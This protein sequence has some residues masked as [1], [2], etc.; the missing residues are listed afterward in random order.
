MK[1]QTNL[2]ALLLAFGAIP[3]VSAAEL[4]KSG[5][6]S[7]HLGWV[8]KGE[9]QALGAN[10]TVTSATIDGVV[11]NDAG[12]GFLNRARADCSGLLDI[13]QGQVSAAGVCVMTDA[14]GDK[15]NLD[16]KC[17]GPMPTCAGDQHF[18]GGT[19]K[20]NGASGNMK[21]QANFIG[22]SSAG[23]SDWSGD[24]ELR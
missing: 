24:Y 23:W 4:P 19:G 6:F 22:N 21:W 10:R 14:D 11:F 7:A 12:K 8:S 15:I 2:A 16:W 18:A 20:Y 17:T 13:N 9:A 1:I 3:S 5:K